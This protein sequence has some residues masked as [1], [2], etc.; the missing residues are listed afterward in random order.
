MFGAAAGD[1]A[2]RA[3]CDAGSPSVGGAAARARA[4]PS[5]AP[6]AHLARQL[7]LAPLCPMPGPAS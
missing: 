7:G 5:A 3:S 2:T 4:A 1:A 6:G